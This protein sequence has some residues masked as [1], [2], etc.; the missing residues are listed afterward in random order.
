MAAVNTTATGSSLYLTRICRKTRIRNL[1][2]LFIGDGGIGAIRS[3]LKALQRLQRS[4]SHTESAVLSEQAMPAYLARQVMWTGNAS[5]FRV[6]TAARLL[7]GTGSAKTACLRK[8]SG[9]AFSIVQENFLEAG[10][11]LFR[12]EILSTFSEPRKAN[13]R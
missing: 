6:V 7:F 8:N 9:S 4:F 3:E 2:I 10:Q 12:S 13:P 1:S 5:N 11:Q